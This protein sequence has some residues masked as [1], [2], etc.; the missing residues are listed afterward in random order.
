MKISRTS[1]QSITLRTKWC[2]LLIAALGLTG[3]GLFGKEPPKVANLPIPVPQATSEDVLKIYLQTM[4]ALG[5]TDTARQS[6]VFFEVEREYK[7]APTS[8]ATLRY[9]LA[10]IT[11]GHPGA[12]PADGKRILEALV[13]NQEKLSPQERIFADILL[14]QVVARLKFEAENRR[15]LATLEET[16]RSQANSDKRLLAQQS[17]EIAN[18]TEQ[19]KATQKKLDRLKEIERTFIERSPTSPGTR[20]TP[21]ETQSPPPGR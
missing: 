20:D 6:D 1:S 5:S 4:S 9:A 12:K 18:L 13:A 2:G 21:S 10:L 19:L 7:R 15:L 17:A 16:R 8:S 3:C 11:P 14:T